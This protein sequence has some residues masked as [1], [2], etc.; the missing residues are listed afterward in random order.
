MRSFTVACVGAAVV[1]TTSALIPRRALLQTET[2]TVDDFSLVDLS[3]FPA[4]ARG[5]VDAGETEQDADLGIEVSRNMA[6]S[7]GTYML[8]PAA[9]LALSEAVSALVCPSLPPSR[10]PPLLCS[11]LVYYHCIIYA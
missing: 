4:G 1:G 10:P 7:F 11:V 9:A 2:F 6:G 5:V 3:A 8:P